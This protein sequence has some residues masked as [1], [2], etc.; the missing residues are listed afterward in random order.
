LDWP[1]TVPEA[2]LDRAVG[3]LFGLAI[4]GNLGPETELGLILAR[5]LVGHSHY[6][7]DTTREA[8]AAWAGSGGQHA[9]PLVRAIGIGI[10]A[11]DPDEAATTAR[12]DCPAEPAAAALASAI[13]VRVRG[14]SSDAMRRWLEP[15]GLAMPEPAPTTWSSAVAG[16]LAGAAYGRNVF[17]VPQVMHILTWRP[18]AGLG[19][20]RPR[21]EIC[22]TDD[23]VDLAEAL[24]RR[25][26]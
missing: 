3:C 26:F 15:A 5:S 16:A 25:S 13:A 24:L 1:R 2:T 20:A 12:L 23:L 9:S 8:V 14:G 11:R 19:V 6:D 22:W 21:P 7:A 17:P 18:D 4:G 10:W